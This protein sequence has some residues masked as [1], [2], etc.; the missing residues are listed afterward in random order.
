MVMGALYC[1]REYLGQSG[2]TVAYRSFVRPVCEYGGI[3][4]ASAVHLHK[5]D[6]VQKMAKKLREVTFSSLSA[7]REASAIGLLCKLLDSQCQGPLQTFCPTL[8]SITCARSL[9]HVIDDPLLLQCSTRYNSLDLFKNS[10]L[11]MIATIWPTIPLPLRERE[12]TEGWSAVRRLLQRH[13]H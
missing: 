9:R 6:S 13:F 10:F 12:T 2:F 7:H 8:V 3:M 5:L 11:G 4:G 1:I